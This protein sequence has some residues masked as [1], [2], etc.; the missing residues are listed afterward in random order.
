MKFT[1][2]E[3]NRSQ[4]LKELKMNEELKSAFDEWFYG[5][6]GFHLLCERFYD[7]IS[8]PNTLERQEIAKEWLKSAFQEGYEFAQINFDKW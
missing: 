3:M 1:G 2:G 8:I 7:E 5:L 4:K 6:E